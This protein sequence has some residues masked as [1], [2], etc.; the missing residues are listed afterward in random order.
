MTSGRTWRPGDPVEPL[1]EHL[2]AGGVAAIPTESSYGLAVLPGNRRGV[3]A[4]YRLKGRDAGKPLPVVAG[5]LAQVAALGIDVST[6]AVRRLSRIWPAALTAVLPTSRSLPAAA[7]EGTL[8]V[9]IPEHRGLRELLLDL[10]EALTATSANLSGRPP[11]LDPMELAGAL[12]GWDGWTVDGGRLPGGPPSTLV[13][14]E[15]DSWRV[16]R[17]GRYPIENLEGAP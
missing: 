5:D 7:G 10:G 14:R 8:A 6:E 15:E 3:E 12:P 16:L 13:R 4:V 17:A 9:R 11:V 2:A 1:R